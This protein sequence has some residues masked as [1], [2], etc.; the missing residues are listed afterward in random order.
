MIF[1]SKNTILS[2]LTLSP[3]LI[4]GQMTS[5]IDPSSVLKMEASDDILVSSDSPRASLRGSL[6]MMVGDSPL[7]K[8]DI[9][10]VYINKTSLTKLIV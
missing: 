5:G 10:V 1:F 3:S 2:L 8:T 6:D 4:G 7:N 9:V